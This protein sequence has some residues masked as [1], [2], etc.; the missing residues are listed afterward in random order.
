ML[1]SRLNVVDTDPVALSIDAF[2]DR[3]RPRTHWQRAGERGLYSRN[4]RV[5]FSSYGRELKV[6]QHARGGE[7][8]RQLHTSSIFVTRLTNWAD[9]AELE[10]YLYQLPAADLNF[11]YVDSPL[12]IVKNEWDLMQE[13]I[14]RRLEVS[15]TR[16]SG[17][18]QQRFHSLVKAIGEHGIG[19]KHG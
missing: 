9:H 19:P 6:I 7:K 18:E 14:E 15:E 11:V 16:I 10:A 17:D 4:S 3:E 13:N 5:D 1:N 12:G 2:F 8:R